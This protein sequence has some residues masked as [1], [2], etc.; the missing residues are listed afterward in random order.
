[1]QYIDQKNQEYRALLDRYD[2]SVPESV[3]ADFY[4]SV[5]RFRTSEMNAGLVEEIDRFFESAL[6]DSA[7]E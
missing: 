1:V 3:L 2:G 4:A 6:L 5:D 7:G